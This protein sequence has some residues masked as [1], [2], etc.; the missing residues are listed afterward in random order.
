MV[1]TSSDSASDETD[2][3]QEFFTKVAGV[4]YQN[5]DGSLRQDIIKE[6]HKVW[7]SEVAVKFT[8]RREPYNP[9]DQ[10]AVAVLDSQG[11]QVGYLSRQ[12]AEFVASKMDK[13]ESVSAEL[14]AITGDGFTYNYGLNIRVVV[15]A[16]PRRPTQP[17]TNKSQSELSYYRG[18]V[19][20]ISTHTF[21]SQATRAGLQQLALSIAYEVGNDGFVRK[22][23]F[24]LMG[25]VEQDSG[26]RPGVVTHVHRVPKFIGSLV[27]VLGRDDPGNLWFSDGYRLPVSR[28]YLA[29]VRKAGHPIGQRVLAVERVNAF[30][31]LLQRIADAGLQP[32]IVGSG[33]K[34]I[35]QW[36]EYTHRASHDPGFREEME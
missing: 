22:F 15:P 18:D 4:T 26:A 10:N 8:L 30:F 13:G 23:D 36:A 29:T 28:E 25:P 12:I 24:V 21:L 35:L 14:Q 6:L 9:Y 3:N 33:L 17:S 2:M 16:T 11:R 27:G 34:P 31:D 32:Q 1:Y 7:R 19:E 20:T 5:A